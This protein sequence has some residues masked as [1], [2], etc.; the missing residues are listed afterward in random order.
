MIDTDTFD[1]N[2]FAVLPRDNNKAVEIED[3]DLS[4]RIH[5]HNYRSLLFKRCNEDWSQQYSLFHGEFL[6][7]NWKSGEE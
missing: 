1:E 5:H 2:D 3:F 7:R 4:A 6:Y